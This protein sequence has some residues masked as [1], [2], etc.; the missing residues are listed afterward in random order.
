MRKNAPMADAGMHR[1][2]PAL[3]VR[4]MVAAVAYY[5]ERFGFEV[6]HQDGG[7][8]VLR[9]DEAVIHLWESSDEEWRSRADFAE[10][11]VCSGAESFIA[12]TASA[13]IEVRDVDGLYEELAAEEVLHPVSRGGVEDTGFGTREFSALD[14]DGN[15]LGFFRWVSR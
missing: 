4:D 1:T 8:A 3:P 5:G 10:K 11:P 12:G 15:L 2:I 7:F 9:R 13:R 14:R 6:I